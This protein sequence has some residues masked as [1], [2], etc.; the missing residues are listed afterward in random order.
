[1]RFITTF[2]LLLSFS[3]FCSGELTSKTEKTELGE[4]TTYFRNGD[5]ILIEEYFDIGTKETG[6]RYYDQYVILDGQGVFSLSTFLITP[7]WEI[8]G[9]EG[10]NIST[11][12]QDGLLLIDLN[13]TR[14]GFTI[15]EEGLL[16]PFSDSEYEKSCVPKD[17]SY[18]QNDQPDEE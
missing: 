7:K 1:M 9:I 11:M 14:E 8:K 17:L 3:S 15:N 5:K 16:V 18:F 4:C 12:P 13:E 6:R 2:L 10:L